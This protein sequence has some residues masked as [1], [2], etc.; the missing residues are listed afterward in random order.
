MDA[1][2]LFAGMAIA[3]TA[4][5]ASARSIT[6]FAGGN[7]TAL[8]HYELG[9][10][11]GGHTR[12]NP[13]AIYSNVDNFTGNA[14]ANGGTENQ[15]GNLIT[16][17]V[18]DDTTF[19]AGHANEQITR[20]TFAVSNG[21]TVPVSVRVRIRFWNNDAA[22]GNPGSYY[23]NP[24]AVGFTFNAFTFSPGVT[25][26]TGLLAAGS[27]NAPASGGTIWSG[28]TFDNNIGATGATQ[29]QMDLMGVGL[30]NPPTVGSSTDTMFETTAAGSF[31]TIANPAGAQF[32]FGGAPV[33]NVGWEFVPAPGSMA[34]LGL[35]GLMAARRRR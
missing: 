20:T 6:E 4:G 17:M 10:P 16:R 26:L 21:S 27:F 28:M 14:F 35:G 23:S 7:L 5:T 11:S 9:V 1:K 22:G 24:A 19:A 25:L 33:A 30:F 13:N 31:F 34:L 2:L 15:A 3:V 8:R 12:S 32:N 29:A 18:M